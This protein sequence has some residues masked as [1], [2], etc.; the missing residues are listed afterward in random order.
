MNSSSPPSSS[1]SASAAARALE[2]ELS[3]RS[4]SEAALEAKRAEVLS[5]LR[6][7]APTEYVLRCS[8]EAAL[9][10][11]VA[12]PALS[13]FYF[14]DGL[15][16]ARYPRY[17]SAPAAPLTFPGLT[18]A[19]LRS[20]A[21]S[22]ARTVGWLTLTAGSAAAAKEL[23]RLGPRHQ[24]PAAALQDPSRHVLQFAAGAGSAAL[25]TADWAA[26][27]GPLRRNSYVVWA[28]LVGIFLP[29][30]LSKAAPKVKE[31]IRALIP[32]S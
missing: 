5:A 25:F 12:A 29:N 6:A 13:L 10:G 1:G 11:L 26:K 23:L 19:A 16:S 3:Q 21:S 27:I 30:L 14:L 28:G 8:G 18:A 24:D 31:S 15:L 32:D 20:C 2:E 22:T 17:G 9:T 7:V 4:S